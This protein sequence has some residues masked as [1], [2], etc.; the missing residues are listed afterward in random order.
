MDML[1]RVIK[2]ELYQLAFPFQRKLPHCMTIAKLA[3]AIAKNLEF[4]S[5]WLQDDV[6][7]AR[8]LTFYI[9]V[10]LWLDQ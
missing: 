4:D 6:K 8:I 1:M 10:A 7:S 2:S 9:P 5:D 3:G